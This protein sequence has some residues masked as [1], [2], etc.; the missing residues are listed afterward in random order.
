M[1]IDR[2]LVDAARATGRPHVRVYAFD[3]PTVTVGRS[4]DP[5]HILDLDACRVRGI[6]VAQRPTGGRAVLHD[7]EVT[8]CVAMLDVTGEDVSRF[9]GERLAAALRSLGVDAE[10]LRTTRTPRAG[11]TAGYRSCFAS[12]ARWEVAARGRKIVG[13]AQR[14]WSD[15]VLQ[16]GS[17]L[18][19]P[20]F[21]GLPRLLRHAEG[22]D[23]D[24]AFATCIEEE[25]RRCVTRESVE[26]ALLDALQ[27]DT[28]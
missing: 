13:S 12:A 18:I 26:R 9:T 6:G 17:I 5:A 4:E 7:N 14:R 2:A 21:R 19:G 8:Y 23:A 10:A 22:A 3:P 24:L 15:A 27:I 11:A 1:Q 20:Q 25:L 16:H 28:L